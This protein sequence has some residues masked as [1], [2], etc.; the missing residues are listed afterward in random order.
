MKKLKTVTIVLSSILGVIVVSGVLLLEYGHVH[1]S[2]AQ[3]AVPPTV[4]QRITPMPR[5][6]PQPNAVPQPVKLPS[7]PPKMVATQSAPARPVVPAAQTVVVPKQPENINDVCS[8]FSQYPSWY[9]DTKQSENKWGVP[10]H[11]Q[12]ATMYQESKFVANA[13]PP[14]KQY[15]WGVIPWHRQSSAVGFCQALNNS[16]KD[17]QDKTGNCGSR[18]DFASAA[19]FIGWYGNMMHHYFGIPSH[20]AYAFY[21]AYHEGP[22]G[23]LHHSYLHKIWLIHV[24][25]NVQKRSHTYQG[26]LQDCRDKL[27]QLVKTPAVAA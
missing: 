6:V 17:F 23:Y 5:Q 25:F 2:L 12:M 4:A 16:W 24:A 19:D 1:Q 20:D 13:K 9:T 26:Q 10:I 8:I 7:K 27:E 18:S 3:L 11:V 15:L 22:G 21:L 14:F